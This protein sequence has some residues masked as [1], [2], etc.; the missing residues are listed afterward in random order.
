MEMG[1]FYIA[2]IKFRSGRSQEEPFRLCLY[3]PI[4]HPHIQIHSLSST[5]GWCNLSLECETPGTTENLAVTW[6]SEG[7]RRELEQ[8]GALGSTPSSRKLSLS[9]LW[10][11]LN[12]LLTCVVSSPVDEKNATLSLQSVCPQRG[13]LQSKWLWSGILPMVLVAASLMAGIWFWMTK[14]RLM[15]RGV[16]SLL[17]AVP[18]SAAAPQALAT[19]DSAALQACAANS[20]AVLYTEIVPLHQPKDTE[21]GGGRSHSPTCTPVVHTVYERIRARPDPQGGRQT[22][23]TP[24]SEGPW[25]EPAPPPCAPVPRDS[26]LR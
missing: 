25:Q 14:K 22:T 3:E 9:L 17:P 16:S 11:Q 5:S 24:D 2:N 23:E 21:K 6:L 13:S 7:L 15:G 8:S 19:E 10:S 1:G 26:S 20:P 12:G 18:G 4:P